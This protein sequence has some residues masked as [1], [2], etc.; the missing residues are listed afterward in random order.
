LDSFLDLADDLKSAAVAGKQLATVWEQPGCPYCRQMHL[1][2]FAQKA[3]ETYIRDHFEVVQLN[4]RGS[5]IVTDFDGEQL[6][7]RQLAAKYGIG[8][9]P[10]IQFCSDK[11]ER[12]RKVPLEREVSRIPGYAPPRPFLLMFSFVGEHAYE[13]ESLRDYLRQQG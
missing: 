10:I 1:V 4:L 6:G 13:R 7:E 9:T 11:D 8:G 3:V 2:N 5:R 12:S